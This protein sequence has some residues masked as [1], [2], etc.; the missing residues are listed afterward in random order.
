M[1][2]KNESETENESKVKVKKMKKIRF[3]KK[4]YNEREERKNGKYKQYI[5]LNVMPL[6]DAR[7]LVSSHIQLPYYVRITMTSWA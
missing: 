4:K 1:Q 7:D 5:F 2:V 3:K 6:Q